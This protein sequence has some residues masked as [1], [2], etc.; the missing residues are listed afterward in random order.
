MSEIIILD[1]ETSGLKPY[2][3]DII[4]IGAKVFET[5]KQFSHL[6]QPKSNEIIS[7]TITSL[8]GISNKMLKKEGLTWQNAYK[9]FNEWLLSVRDQRQYCKGFFVSPKITIVSHNGESFDFLFLKRMF[10]DLNELGI[11]TIPIQ[12][13]IFIDTLLLSKRLLPNR[14]SHRQGALCSF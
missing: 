10:N 8:T 11:E 7:E 6:V 3:D 13:I 12:D 5:E 9:S 14:S 1:F 2:K 4:E